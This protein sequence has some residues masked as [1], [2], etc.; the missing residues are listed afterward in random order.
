MIQIGSPLHS[1]SIDEPIDLHFLSLKHS[2][3]LAIHD[4]T[5]TDNDSNM[6]CINGKVQQI[7]I[8]FKDCQYSYRRLISFANYINQNSQLF[9]KIEFT[10]VY[11]ED[12][13]NAVLMNTK[14]DHI[15]IKQD[16]I[17][18]YSIVTL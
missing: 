13:F 8:R 1:I 12:I 9:N 6:I 7:N 5:F 4:V 18:K 14:F 11:D 17:H 2:I 3:E 10:D 15:A 16:G